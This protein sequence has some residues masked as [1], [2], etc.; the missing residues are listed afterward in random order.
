MIISNNNNGFYL[1]SATITTTAAAATTYSGFTFGVPTAPVAATTTS[2]TTT[3]A[4]AA[5]PITTAA[6][7]TFTFGN[8]FLIAHYGLCYMEGDEATEADCVFGFNLVVELCESLMQEHRLNFSN[9]R[10]KN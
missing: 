3:V 6:L 9:S 1:A 4:P 2:A 10:I 8:L 5:T 7:R